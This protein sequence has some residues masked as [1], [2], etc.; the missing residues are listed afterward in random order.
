MPYHVVGERA[1]ALALM[2]AC[3]HSAMAR[4]GSFI[5][6]IFAN[7]SLSPVS[8]LLLPLA[9]AFSSLAYSFTA[10]FSS[11]VNPLDF[12]ASFFELIGISLQREARQR[13][14][15]SLRLCTICQ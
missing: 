7:R 8:L 13:R 11:A 6:A 14:P 2:M 15:E 10:A 12:C 9:S 1:G 4:S 5:S 3:S